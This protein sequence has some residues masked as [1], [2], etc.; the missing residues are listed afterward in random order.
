MVEV[1]ESVEWTRE[2][3]RKEEMFVPLTFVV[4]GVVC[5]VPRGRRGS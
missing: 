1:L 3:S 4:V 2:T 5:G